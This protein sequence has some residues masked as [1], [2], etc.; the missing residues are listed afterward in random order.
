MSQ[1]PKPTGDARIEDQITRLNQAAKDARAAEKALRDERQRTEVALNGMEEVCRLG[2]RE[3]AQELLTQES[4]LLTAQLAADYGRFRDEIFGRL[5]QASKDVVDRFAQLF[6]IADRNDMLASV[7]DILFKRLEAS[8][9][10]VLL[11]APASPGNV[12]AGAAQ[13]RALGC[14][15]V[16]CAE[17]IKYV[18]ELGIPF[19]WRTPTPGSVKG[20]CDMHG[21][22]V[23]VGPDQMP[24]MDKVPMTLC[25][26][27]VARLDK[28]VDVT[29][30]SV[31]DGVAKLL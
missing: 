4:M 18:E 11:S 30:L 28:K 5:V 2:M 3:T 19:K 14:F 7:A 9:K 15:P 1:R 23:W 8:D 6:G 20:K 22:P 27:C 21:G 26:F 12:A 24:F 31:V 25:L 29:V 13:G 10:G 16:K 17:N